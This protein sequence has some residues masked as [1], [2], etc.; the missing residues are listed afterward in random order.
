MVPV[1]LFLLFAP[2][3]SCQL[4]ASIGVSLALYNSIHSLPVFGQAMNS[5]KKTVLL[6]KGVAAGVGEGV[7]LGLGEGVLHGTVCA[8]ADDPAS[9]T[10]SS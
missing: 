8:D 5:V 2:S 3:T 1:I 9:A 10:L 4:V 6:A 7:A